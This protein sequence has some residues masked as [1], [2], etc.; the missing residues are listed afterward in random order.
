MRFHD[1]TISANIIISDPKENYFNSKIF[2]FR[3]RSIIVIQIHVNMAEH[4][5]KQQHQNEVTRV[6]V[7]NL[8]RWENTVKKVGFCNNFCR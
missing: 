2:F 8:N 4:A 7:M 6:N 1:F 5:T 3:N